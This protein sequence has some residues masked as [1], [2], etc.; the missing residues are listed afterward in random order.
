MSLGLRFAKVFAVMPYP[1]PNRWRSTG[2][3]HAPNGP[4]LLLDKQLAAR[5]QKGSRH[6]KR[7]YDRQKQSS[8]VD[9]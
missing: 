9:I 5:R 1:T 2:E 8:G 3:E 7:R 4:P 6:P